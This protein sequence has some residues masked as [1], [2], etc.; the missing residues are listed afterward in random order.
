[1]KG[2]L[3]DGTRKYSGNLKEIEIQKRHESKGQEIWET[4]ENSDKK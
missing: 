3:K 4:Q 1:L 2:Y